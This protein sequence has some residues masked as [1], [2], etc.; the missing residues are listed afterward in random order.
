MV[1]LFS[2]LIVLCILFSCSKTHKTE[3]VYSDRGYPVLYDDGFF[4]KLDMPIENLWW[5][6]IEVLEAY[7]WPVESAL[8]IDGSIRTEL[9]VMGTN[10]DRYACREWIGS[11]ARI[12]QLRARLE[13]QLTGLSDGTSSLAVNAEIEGRYVTTSGTEERIAGWFQCASTGEIEGEIFD[14]VLGRLEPIWYDDP[15]FRQG[16]PAR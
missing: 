6:M 8:E 14:A 1:R 5:T 16:A 7:D 15:I 12:D 9:L 11:S 4:V 3:V 13:I 2:A 10:R